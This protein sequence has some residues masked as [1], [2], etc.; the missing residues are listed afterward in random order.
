[1]AKNDKLKETL[2]ESRHD[3][4]L[5]FALGAF[6]FAGISVAL[7]YWQIQGWMSALEILVVLAAA[8]F[9][10]NSISNRKKRARKKL[11]EQLDNQEQPSKPQTLTS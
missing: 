5:G 8:M 4:M 10:V 2:A 11:I 7:A 6:G 1:M 3:D 9:G